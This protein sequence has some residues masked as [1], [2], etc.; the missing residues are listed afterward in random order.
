MT[1]PPDAFFFRATCS[2]SHLYIQRA[3]TSLSLSRYSQT[4]PPPSYS[5]LF[6]SPPSFSLVSLSLPSSSILVS[7]LLPLSSR[8]F[9]LLEVWLQASDFMSRWTSLS[10]FV[11]CRCCLGHSIK[12]NKLCPFRPK[13]LVLFVFSA[14]QLQQSCPP[15]SLTRP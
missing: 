4:T 11:F 9:L 2:C 13:C 8:A 3:K 10:T 1:L 6:S 7:F 14:S 15:H 12:C 5:H